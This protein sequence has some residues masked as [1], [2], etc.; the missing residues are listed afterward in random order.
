MKTISICFYFKGVGHA[1]ISIFPSEGIE[2]YLQESP[3]CREIL[4]ENGDY[5]LR[6]TGVVSIPDATIKI[7]LGDLEVASLDLPVG[8]FSRPI[9]F[10]IQ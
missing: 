10:S 4:F 1:N 2:P 3:G 6:A 7:L 9:N 8:Y 5:L